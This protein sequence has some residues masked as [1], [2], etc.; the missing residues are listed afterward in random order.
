MKNKLTLLV[1]SFVFLLTC[2]PIDVFATQPSSAIIYMNEY[3]NRYENYALGYKIHIYED[4][5]VDESAMDV[6]TRFDNEDTIIDIYF[7]DFTNEL[8]NF[9]TYKNYGNKSL[10]DNSL[11]SVEKSKNFKV[12]GIKSHMIYYRRPKLSNIKNDKNY[13]ACVEIPRTNDKIYT[14]IMKSSEPISDFESIVNT[15]EFIDKTASLPSYKTTST[16]N[17]PMSKETEEF[18][19]KTFSDNSNLEFGVYEPTAPYDFSYLRKL[20]EN[21]DYD[22]PVIVRYQ[23][24]DENFPRND[25]LSAK[26]NNKVVELTMQTTIKQGSKQDLTF[27]ILNGEYDDYFE[28]YAKDL[29]ALDYPVLFRL[30]NEMNGDWCMYSAYHYGKDADLYVELYRYIYDIFRENG[31]D[32][33]IFVWNPNERSFPNFAWNHYMSYYPG[34]EYVDV[35]GLTGYNT[36]TYYKGETW[37]SFENIYD[38]IYYEYANRFSQPLMIAEFAS[39]SYGGDKPE[40]IND[41]FSKIEKYDRIKLAVWW[42][43]IDWDL[44]RNPARIYKIDESS[45]VIEAIRKGLSKIKK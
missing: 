26:Y 24:M 31:A 30:N 2:L 33:A 21:L 38:G 27:N 13:Y 35:V 12:S 20:Q 10:Y 43:G 6:R 42:S 34:D 37:R 1:L 11:F 32:N 4:M 40:W 14:I 5:K 8:D 45:S 44:K 22:F 9:N 25:M 23:H 36:G 19:N 18:Y 29:K 39:S 7:D 17:R 41:M 15:F 16:I 3:T 28:N